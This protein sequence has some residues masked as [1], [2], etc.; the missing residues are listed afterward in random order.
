MIA[1]PDDEGETCET[2]AEILVPSRMMLFILDIELINEKYPG[3]SSGIS[4][5][6]FRLQSGS[7]TI[8]A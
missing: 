3:K 8:S 1:F 6:I 5:L 7:R 4:V 2:N